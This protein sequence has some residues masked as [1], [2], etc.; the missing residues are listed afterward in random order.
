MS[1]KNMDVNMEGN[2]FMI[3]LIPIP[4]RLLKWRMNIMENIYKSSRS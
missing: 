3:V 4:I 1:K 2:R